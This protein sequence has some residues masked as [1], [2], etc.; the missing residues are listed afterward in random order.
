MEVENDG[1][2]KEETMETIVEKWNKELAYAQSKFEPFHK[3]AE[4]SVEKFL[5]KKG[6][7]GANTLNLYHAN[8]TTLK[9]MLFGRTPKV[10]VDRRYADANDDSARVAGEII[11][12]I[13][14]ADV[15]EPGDDFS[16][17]LRNNLDDRLLAGLGCARLRYDFEKEEVQ[18]AAQIDPTTGVELAPA[19]TEKRIKE[20]W[21]DTVYV[22]WK[23]VL[24]NP[25]RFW[26]EVRWIAFRGYY[27]RKELIEM[28]GE[29]GRDIPLN[30]ESPLKGEDSKKED[31]FSKAEVW[32]IW[33]K[34]SGQVYHF[35]KGHTECPKYGPPPLELDDFFPLPIPMMSNTTTSEMIPKPDYS[36]SCKLYEDID[37][38]QERIDL[39]T[40]ACKL[41]GVYDKNSPDVKRL[42]TEGVENQLI[43]VDNWAMFA[44]KQGLAGVIQWLPL[45]DVVAA[46]DT[47]SVKQTEKINQ[48][49]QVTGMSDILRGGGDPRASATQDGLKA[50]FASVRIQSMQDEFAR[51]AS[52]LQK[53]KFEIISKY[54]QPE[55][56]MMASNIM[57]TVDADAV[58]G[59]IELIKNWEATTWKINVAPETL[60][61]VDF[62]Q[63][64]QERTEY[65]DALGIFLQSAAPIAEKF[66]EAS[67]VLLEL[68][69]WG[70]AGFKGSRQIEGV[71]DKAVAAMMKQMGA[72]K[73]PD[74]EV[75]KMQEEF[76]LKQQESQQKLQLAQQQGQQKIQQQQQEFQLSM[77]QMMAEFSMKMKE[78]QAKL[79]ANNQEI[80]IKAE[81]NRMNLSYQKETAEVAAQSAKEMA[82]IKKSQASEKKKDD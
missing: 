64:R 32:E 73:P 22:H 30:A 59:A 62:S 67:P 4:K 76:K 40:E 70:L 81:E 18:V 78:L 13:L 38:L 35:V 65:I 24:W 6:E 37:I 7:K 48:L 82:A 53:L 46:V 51:F 42:L 43:P 26:S 12:R 69:K 55:T 39:L 5:D 25:C 15:N 77:Q 3:Q 56:I 47:L 1:T 50:K 2:P 16:L 29:K 34:D 23:D 21:V 61:M 28:Y 68:L 17:V 63:L 49:Y 54:F 41:V 72:P 36:M 14:N 20:E 8:V 74:P 71:L 44:E 80:A 33:C 75:M 60:A 52:D 10:D 31:T 9:A 27:D 66:P 19:Y 57:S 45:K 11:T 79:D 58:P